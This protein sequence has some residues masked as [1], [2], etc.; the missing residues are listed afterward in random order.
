MIKVLGTWACRYQM[1]PI[2]KSCFSYCIKMLM[3][4]CGSNLEKNNALKYVTFC[5]KNHLWKREEKY[6]K[7]INVNKENQKKKKEL[8]QEIIIDLIC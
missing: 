5:P 1:P 7:I 6:F 8:E 2:F 3:P 4:F